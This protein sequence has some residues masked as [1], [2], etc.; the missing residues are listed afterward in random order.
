[1]IQDLIY[2]CP[3]CGAL[4]WYEKG[5]CIH[6]NASVE[7]VSRTRLA[8]NSRDEPIAYWY[9]LVYALDLPEDAAGKIL[10]ASDVIL[11]R[12]KR[13]STFKGY[14]GITATHY[15]RER[16][17]RGVLTLYGS[18]IVFKGD[19]VNLDISLSDIVSLTIESNTLIIVIRGNTTYF[20]DFRRDSGKKWED[21][22]RKAISRYHEGEDIVEF[23]PRIRFKSD[24]RLSVGSNSVNGHN[25]L[26]VPVHKWY[27][28]DGSFIYRPISTAIRGLIKLLFPVTIYGMGNIPLEGPA[29]IMPN[30]LSF[31][32]SVIL[33]V[34]SRRNIWFMGK[35]S[36]FMHPFM[37]WF[38][39]VAKAFPV[40]RYTIDVQAIRNSIRVA[41]EGHILGI[42]PEGE[43]SW[44]GRMLPFKY[45]TMRL[46][47]ALGL[48]VIPVGISGSYELL[49]R[50]GGGLKRVPIRINIG[51]P[52]HFEQVPIPM[53][54]HSDIEKASNDLK[55]AIMQLRGTGQ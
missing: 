16:L 49:P 31:L 43:R 22:L 17:D 44:D 7:L 46:M 37:K 5:R 20:I 26:R 40:R 8:I 28:K 32:D 51:K 19:D 29:I 12:D 13:S 15:I 10:Q 1:M 24:L 53:Q 54:R 2:R 25:E 4:D 11:S 47:L 42:F 36:E 34:F 14:A 33:G 45:G 41:Q 38:L 48:P 30:H 39:R 50:W 21:F 27:T 23:Y 18:R 55:S 9:D 3:V 35:N 6:C 52:M